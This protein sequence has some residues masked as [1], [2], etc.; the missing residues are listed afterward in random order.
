MGFDADGGYAERCVRDGDC[1]FGLKV[2]EGFLRVPVIEE[3]YFEYAWV[4][5]VKNIAI[6]HPAFRPKVKASYRVW[7]RNIRLMKLGS[8]P[9]VNMVE[10]VKKDP[11]DDV[12]RERW[13]VHLAFG[14]DLG[15][16]FNWQIAFTQA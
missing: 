10:H 7:F 9:G 14:D 8:Q 4:G 13:Q 16:K 6:A 1:G 15:H 2:L 12:A 5:R 11:P 3:S